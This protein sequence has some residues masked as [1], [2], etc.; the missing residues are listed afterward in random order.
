MQI[1]VVISTCNRKRNLLFLLHNL[2]TSDFLLEEVIIVDSGEE[3]LSSE[4]IS[5][6]N[7]LNI[8]YIFSEKSVCIQRNVG[9]GIAK[10]EWIFLCDD[11]IEPPSDYLSKLS[12]HRQK[13]PEASAVS[14]LILQKEKSK[15]VSNYPVKSNVD[16]VWRYIF[17]LSI[18]GPLQSNGSGL[19]IK[20]IQQYYLRK[21]NHISKAGWPVLTNFS[22][23]YFETPVYGL[24]ASLIKKEWLLHSPFDETLDRHGIGDNYGVAAKFPGKIHVVNNAFVYHHQEETNRLHHRI[25]YY[26]RILALDYFRRTIP[27]LRFIKKRWLIWSLVG[28]FILYIL[29]GNFFMIRPTAKA[30]LK[31]AFNNN[32]Y[33]QSATKNKKVTAPAL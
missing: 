12:E 25:A 20:K 17:K 11:D 21:G 32:D 3:R 26:R 14:G 24:G 6:F 16:L 31:I 15:W 7:H 1:S 5:H 13:H 18:W 28:N 8:Q 27:S 4:E 33:I 2:N 19:I 30:I 9:I 23:D 10:S 29:N 22:G